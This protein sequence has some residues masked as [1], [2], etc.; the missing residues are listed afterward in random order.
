MDDSLTPWL[1]GWPNEE[2]MTQALSAMLLAKVWGSTPIPRTV[3]LSTFRSIPVAPSCASEVGYESQSLIHRFTYR[4]KRTAMIGRHGGG[5]LYFE[6]TDYTGQ[7][8]K[9]SISLALQRLCC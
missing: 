1:A 3:W 9:C 7:A 8:C 5:R 6:R 2:L 4:F